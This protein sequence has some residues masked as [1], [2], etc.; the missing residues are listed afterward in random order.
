[1]AARVF[2]RAFKVTS[3]EYEMPFNKSSQT[4]HDTDIMINMYGCRNVA[5]RNL[6]TTNHFDPHT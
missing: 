4:Q 2:L 6:K 1:M 5:K 3:F